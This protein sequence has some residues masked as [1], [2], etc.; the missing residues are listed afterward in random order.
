MKKNDE[1]DSNKKLVYL[2]ETWIHATH[3]VSKCCQD[4]KTEGV[5]KNN[6]A[7]Q[8]WIIVHA[9]LERVFFSRGIADF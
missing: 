6:S 7:G 8:R 2:D 5:M 4:S 1:L 3:T 9:G